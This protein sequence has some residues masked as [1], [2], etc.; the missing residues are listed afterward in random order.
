LERLI[1]AQIE[2]ILLDNGS[3]E[4]TPPGMM[5]M[6]EYFRTYEPDAVKRRKMLLPAVAKGLRK[7]ILVQEKYKENS[8]QERLNDFKQRVRDYSESC[9]MQNVIRYKKN[10]FSYYLR[11]ITGYL[12]THP[13]ERE[14]ILHLRQKDRKKYEKDYRVINGNDSSLDSLLEE[15]E[16]NSFNL[17]Q[18]LIFKLI[19]NPDNK[20]IQTFIENNPVGTTDCFL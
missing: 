6:K 8:R 17:F 5:T 1:E 15:S 10:A 4:L 19:E 3:E 14:M 7:E 11:S 9:Q 18:I 20:I 12:K 13:V 2:N 16:T